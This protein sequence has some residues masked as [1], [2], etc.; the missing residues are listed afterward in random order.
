MLAKANLQDLP[1]SQPKRASKQ[2]L[3]AIGKNVWLPKMLYDGLPYFYLTAGFAAIF[4][5]LYI[6]DWFW[7]LPHYLLFSAACMH[8]AY[9][10]YRQRRNPP[11]TDES[12][13]QPV[14][15]DATE[16]ASAKHCH[17]SAI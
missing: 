3:G 14:T 6:S 17:S 9:V 7:I 11:D 16:A 2:T 5:T 15:R 8:L 12:V 10:V 13:A 4:A 1:I